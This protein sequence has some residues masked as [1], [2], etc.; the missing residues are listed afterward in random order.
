MQSTHQ[1]KRTGSEGNVEPSCFAL[2]VVFQCEVQRVHF[3]VP[4]VPVLQPG[5]HRVVRPRPQRQPVQ[6]RHIPRYRPVPVQIVH[7]EKL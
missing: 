1:T 7:P 4:A 3:H 6:S 2:Q 5:Q